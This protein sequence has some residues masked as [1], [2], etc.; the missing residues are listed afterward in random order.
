MRARR[1]AD[2][3]AGK[4]GEGE[5]GKSL[6]PQHQP[7]VT[8]KNCKVKPDPQTTEQT[9]ALCNTIPFIMLTWPALPLF[10]PLVWNTGEL[11][12]QNVT[13]SSSQKKHSCH[14][15][16]P[17]PKK[18]NSNF[19]ITDGS[20]TTGNLVLKSLY[21]TEQA[22]ITYASLSAPIPTII[23]LLISPAIYHCTSRRQVIVLQRGEKTLHEARAK[24]V[25]F[26]CVC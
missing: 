8:L 15:L 7:A 26:K 1:L 2:T 3:T 5:T 22:P 24:A 19:H 17:V 20:D 16:Y 11:F 25:V 6:P 13:G 10:S 9:R 18:L 12:L 23:S 14:T 21:Y 4:S